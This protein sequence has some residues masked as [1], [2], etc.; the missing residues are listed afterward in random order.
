MGDVSGTYRNSR[1]GCMEGCCNFNRVES[2]HV[3]PASPQ[4]YTGEIDENLYPLL[5]L[6]KN[7]A[8]PMV[9]SYV[10]FTPKGSESV[11]SYAQIFRFPVEAS[12]RYDKD[13][14]FHDLLHA[15][16]ATISLGI[17]RNT[18]GVRTMG[19]IKQ[20]LGR[21]YRIGDGLKLR[22]LRSIRYIHYTDPHMARVYGYCGEWIWEGCV[23]VYAGCAYP[24]AAKID[25]FSAQC[26]LGNVVAHH[27][28][29]AAHHL[30]EIERLT[31]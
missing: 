24:E 13:R 5:A 26:K 8:V 12:D 18:R 25:H 17:S 19:G 3:I 16:N 29:R 21:A 10:S 23:E 11:T 2:S 1:V 30:S 7:N 28:A 4:K 27:A 22:E 9:N 31:R 20:F 15:I 6:A 14:K